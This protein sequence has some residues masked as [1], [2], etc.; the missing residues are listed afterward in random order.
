M[1]LMSHHSMF[2]ARMTAENNLRFFQNL[3]AP[4]SSD[5]ILFALEYTGLIGHRHKFTDGFSRGMI[6]RLMIARLVLAKPSFVFFDEPFTGLDLQGQKLLLSIISHRGIPELK[7]RID[8]FVFVDH[9]IQRAYDLSEIVWVMQSGVL[10]TPLQKTDI[11]LG[12]LMEV[13]K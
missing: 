6:Q 3:Y 1:Q 5:D 12:D 9:D 11:K 13:L 7:W 4:A 8:S 10:E 2:Y